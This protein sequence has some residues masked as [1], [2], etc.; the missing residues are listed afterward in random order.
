MKFLIITTLIFLVFG[1]F[2]CK[3]QQIMRT[4]NDAQKLQ[5]NKRF[6]IG[7]P[8]YTLLK[9]IAPEIKTALVRESSAEN[10]G[11]FIFRFVDRE[12]QKKYNKDRKFPLG[13]TVFVKEKLECNPADKPMGEREKWTKK[14]EKKYGNL[15][16]MDIRVYGEN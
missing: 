14:D 16:V 4:L 3:S 15:T 6:F 11:A 1:S 10:L 8:L 5:S 7:K 9:E 13:I 2:S 12:N